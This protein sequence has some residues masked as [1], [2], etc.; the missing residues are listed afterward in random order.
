[1]TGRHLLQLALGFF[2]LGGVAAIWVTRFL[3]PEEVDGLFTLF[4]LITT[5]PACWPGW[6]S[7]E[8]ER[9]SRER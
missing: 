8:K 2:F 1:M 6:I 7:V 9:G 4:L 5:I 3:T